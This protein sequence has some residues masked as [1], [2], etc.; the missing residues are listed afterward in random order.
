MKAETLLIAIVL[1]GCNAKPDSRPELSPVQLFD[2]RAKCQQTV[3]KD[4]EDLYIAVVG[5]ALVADTK[6]HYNPVTNHCY[7]EV[8]VR[9]NLSYNYPET[10]GNYYS[11]AL[12]DA[13]TR[14]LL[15]AA[16]QKGEQRFGTDW[17][18]PDHNKQT[19]DEV[20]VKINL[21]MTQEQ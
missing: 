18:V 12:Y 19:Y 5:N 7:A 8:D 14:D 3:D 1:V 6:S 4:V 9:K 11:M 10:P 2:L 21:L 13:Q 20:V 17:T 16:D 15:M